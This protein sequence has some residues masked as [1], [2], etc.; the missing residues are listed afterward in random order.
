MKA[1]SYKRM[2]TILQ[3]TSRTFDIPL[4]ILVNL[5]YHDGLCAITN[6]LGYD[7]FINTKYEEFYRSGRYSPAKEKEKTA[8]RKERI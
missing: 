7:D 8:K 6:C 3:D 1:P 2:E 5:I 4:D